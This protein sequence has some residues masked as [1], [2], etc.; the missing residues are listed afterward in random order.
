MDCSNQRVPQRLVLLGVNLTRTV[1]TFV[2][3]FDNCHQMSRFC[4][5]CDPDNEGLGPY[6]L[7]I[8]GS[9]Y[10]EELRLP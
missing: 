2:R 6:I 1:V 3:T 8:T 7:E 4:F 10:S 5:S 9:N